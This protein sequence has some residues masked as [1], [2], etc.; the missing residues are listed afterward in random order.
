MTAARDELVEVARAHNLTRTAE[1]IQHFDH[2]A[3]LQPLRPPDPSLMAQPAPLPGEVLTQIVRRGHH[4]SLVDA[5]IEQIAD[6][7]LEQA[8]VA[9]DVLATSIIHD[10]GRLHPELRRHARAIADVGVT[11]GQAGIDLNVHT[12]IDLVGARAD[13]REGDPTVRLQIADT[14]GVPPLEALHQ[15]VAEMKSGSRPL[16]SAE[17]IDLLHRTRQFAVKVARAQLPTLAM[18][19]LDILA[20]QFQL[21]D[22]ALDLCEVVHDLGRPQILPRDLFER[23]D[24]RPNEQKQLGDYLLCRSAIAQRQLDEVHSIIDRPR[25]PGPLAKHLDVVARHL[26]VLERRPGP[27]SELDQ[28]CDTDRR[29]RYAASVRVLLYAKDPNE[30]RRVLSV[31]FDFIDRFGHD[32]HTSYAALAAAPEGAPWLE[33]ACRLFAQEARRFP[34]IVG[35]W[36]PL[37][38][39]L[40]DED[41]IEY[42]MAEI[43][44]LLKQQT[45]WS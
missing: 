26:D 22:A 42:A 7:P 9:W 19:Y 2:P 4:A 34:H 21:V 11:A 14:G 39:F 20:R 44:G 45:T 5:L 28:I 33:D 25:S 15:L 30:S 8:L 6:R 36:Q 41:G 27:A 29:W 1:L 16:Q 13:R 37:V 18:V 38:T 31:L 35:A 43:N 24:L 10:D 3:A 32:T 17:E 12:G 40:A 23:V